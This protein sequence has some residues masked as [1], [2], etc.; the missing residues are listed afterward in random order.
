MTEKEKKK[1]S[2]GG[3]DIAIR[4]TLF[5][6]P[7]PP[8]LSMPKPVSQKVAKGKRGREERGG[9]GKGEKIW[10]LGTG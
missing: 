6:P 9:G 7:S 5:L 10:E 1:K 2:E 3:D 8:L 4:G